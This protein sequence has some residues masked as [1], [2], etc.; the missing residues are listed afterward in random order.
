MCHHVPMVSKNAKKIETMFSAI[1]PTYDLL[2]RLLSLGMDKRWRRTAIESLSPNGGTYLDAAT[3]T[4]DLAIEIARR[5]G[6]SLIIGADFSHEML[7]IGKTKTAGKN[8]SLWRGDA[9]NLS[10]KDETFD[11]V[12]CAFGIRNFADLKAGL[13]EML[14]VLKPGGRISILEF[15]APANPLIKK[16]YLFYFTRI[17]PIA[18]KL[19]SGHPEAYAYLPASTMDFPDRRKLAEIFI[20]AGFE[21]VAVKPLTLGICDLITGR[22]PG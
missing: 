16:L 10:F 9:L 15:T 7:K 22:R 12:T 6:T 2:N 17:L 18:G 20:E 19:I 21:E 1:A 13:C 14:R 8:I 11:G 4:A 3:G 5:S